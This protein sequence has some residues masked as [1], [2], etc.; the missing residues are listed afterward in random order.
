MNGSFVFYQDVTL[1]NAVPPYFMIDSF[2]QDFVKA[3]YRDEHWS[4]LVVSGSAPSDAVFDNNIWL[5]TK[6][7]YSDN[8]GHLLID[9]LMPVL[10]ALTVF[11]LPSKGSN[12][13]YDGCVD[14]GSVP[15][16]YIANRTRSQVCFE[17]YRKYSPFFL[18]GKTAVHVSE[19]PAK[20]CFST[21]IVGQ[22]SAFSLRS[23]DLQRASTVRKARSLVVNALGLREEQHTLNSTL[24]LLKR[25][26]FQGPPGWP[27]LCNDV[28]QFLV[29]LN[30]PLATCVY[31]V[32]LSFADQVR[33]VRKARAIVAEHG[34]V[35][36]TA[37]FANDGAKLIVI[38]SSSELKEVQ[39]LLFISHIRVWYMTREQKDD[40]R[41]LLYLAHV[42]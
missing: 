39:I 22:S 24:V 16:P 28:N 1:R 41:G 21:F 32:D 2:G 20:K 6:S 40:L 5:F 23:L 34:T 3:G 11:G 15:S 7:S 29:T 36:Y 30:L 10:S 4:P 9:D 33:A 8:F 12:L 25:D 31:P 26:G 37:L 38:G 14:L 17:N 35:A 42:Q 13:L 19:L 27:S 18:H